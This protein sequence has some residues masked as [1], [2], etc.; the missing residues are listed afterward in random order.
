MLM[1]IKYINLIFM[2]VAALIILLAAAVGVV[3]AEGE[4]RARINVEK[5]QAVNDLKC[6]GTTVIHKTPA[7]VYSNKAMPPLWR[8]E[9]AR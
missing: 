3:R 8:V 5:V 4:W 1:R 2:I 7:T 6:G 9:G